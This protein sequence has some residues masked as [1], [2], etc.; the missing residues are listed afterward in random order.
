MSSPFGNF[1]MKFLVNSPLHFLVGR[2]LAV[3]TVTGRKSGRSIA[4]PVNTLPVDGVLTVISQRDRTWWRNLRGEQVTGLRRSGKLV[5]MHASVIETPELVAS[6]LEK[7]FAEYPGYAKYFG[8]RPAP[9]G[10][11]DPHALD[12]L[13]RE[14]VVI[15]LI[16]V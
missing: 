12:D 10:Q 15:Q 4:T 16:P 7:Y 1:F 5:R 8:I 14:R 6:K 9:G 13:S 11:F 2:N 3:I